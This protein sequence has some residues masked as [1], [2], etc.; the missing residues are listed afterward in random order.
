LVTDKQVRRLFA[1][2]KTAGNQQIAAAKAGMDTKTARKYRQLG[3]VPSALPAAPRW[4]TRADPFEEVWAEIQE[5][6]ANQAG[7]EAKT[8]FE[9][10]QRRDPGRFSD[11]QLRTLQRK[12]KAWRATDGPAKEVFFAQEH[13]PGRLGTSDFTHMEELGITVQG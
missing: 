5:L 7:L 8:V 10:L 2:V 13:P 6:L 1:L 11:G 4:P 3:Q 9:H 12:I